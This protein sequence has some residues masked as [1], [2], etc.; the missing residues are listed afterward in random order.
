[1]HSILTRKIDDRRTISHFFT[2]TSK[3]GGG[4]CPVFDS[5]HEFNT[6]SL[7][8]STLFFIGPKSMALV[9][10]A[11]IFRQLH[12]TQASR[13]V[14]MKFVLPI[15]SFLSIPEKKALVSFA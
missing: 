2:I 3:Y 9:L 13:C 5:S 11:L 14:K 15:K 7:F 12:C 6:M 4:T 1:M 8:N 10:L